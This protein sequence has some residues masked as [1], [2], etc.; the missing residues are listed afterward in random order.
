MTNESQTVEQALETLK[1][2]QE[3]RSELRTLEELLEQKPRELEEAQSRLARQAQESESLHEDTKKLQNEANQFEGEIE[4]LEAKI[5]KFSVQ[6]NGVKTNREYAALQD[7]ID[8][9]KLDISRVEDRMLEIMSQTES[10]SE[11]QSA[12][13]K[14]VSEERKRLEEKAAAIQEEIKEAQGEHDELKAEF[15]DMAAKLMPKYREP[16]RRLSSIRGGVAVCG[17][18]GGMC[19]GCFITL[20]MQTINAL[21]GAHELIYCHSCGRILYL[22]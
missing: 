5:A 18:K 21:M 7:E 15:D 1:A 3:R 17:V 20:T 6:Q 19:G 14:N 13:A 9:A 4:D 11:Q 8:N 2:L 16:F 12:A 22:E 10:A